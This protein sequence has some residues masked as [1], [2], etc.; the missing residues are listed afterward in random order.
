MLQFL[1]QCQ[2]FN[3]IWEILMN[4]LMEIDRSLPLLGQD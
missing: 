1:L 4:N 2:F 3:Y